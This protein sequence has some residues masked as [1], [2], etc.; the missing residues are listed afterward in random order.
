[1]RV[2]LNQ[3]L[4]QLQRSCCVESAIADFLPDLNEL[5]SED[6]DNLPQSGKLKRLRGHAQDSVVH[7]KEL[8]LAQITSRQEVSL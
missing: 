7:I 6:V 2:R 3:L 8:G 1:M 4:R 5:G